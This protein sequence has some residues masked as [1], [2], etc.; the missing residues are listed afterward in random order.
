MQQDISRQWQLRPDVLR[1]WLQPVQ[2]EAGGALPLQVPLVLLRDLQEV[3]E[4]R[5]EIRLQMSP[6][7]LI[8]PGLQINQSTTVPRRLNL[9]LSLSMCISTR[10]GLFLCQYHFCNKSPAANQASELF[11][12]TN[13]DVESVATASVGLREDCRPPGFFF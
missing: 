5:G 7:V 10:T 4:D 1:P 3:W 6:N 12:I 2:W 8:Q 13:L 11:R 9:A